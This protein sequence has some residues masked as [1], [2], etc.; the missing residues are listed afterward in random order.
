MGFHTLSIGTSA[1]LTARYGLDVTGQN[2]GNI[3]TPG[4][5][6]QRLN[7]YGSVNSSSALA[8]GVTGN[9]VWVQ[10]IRRV[11]NE[12][13]EKQ[14]RQATSTDEYYGGLSDGYTRLQGYINELRY[15]E[16]DGNA[17]SDTMNNFW[18]AFKD[19]SGGVENLSLRKTPVEMA[20][21]MTGRFNTLGQQLD[22]YRRDLDEEIG[23]SVSQIN[24]ILD[25]IA[26]LNKSIVSSELGGATGKSANDLRD[27]RGE[28]VKELYEYI[29]AD[30]V[31][32]A[33]GSFIVSVHGRN[34]VYFDQVKE[35]VNVKTMSPDGIQVNTPSF[36]EDRYPLNPGDGKL[37]AQMELRDTIIP[38]Y[39]T[40]VDQ[41]AGNFIWEFN[42]VYSQTRGLEP[43]TNMTAKNGPTNP[44]ATLNNLKYLEQ[45]IVPGTFEI[46]DGDFDIV[47]VNK[48]TGESYT[49]TVEIDLDGRPGPDGEPDTILYDPNNPDA[50]N[51]LINRLQAKFDDAVPG[52]F[53]VSIDRNNQ[54]TITAKSSDY[55]FAFANDT[56]GVLAALGMNTFFT[57]HNATTM[58][59]DDT[60]VKNPSLM[61]AAYSGNSGDNNGALDILAVQNKKLTTL[62]GMTMDEHYQSMVGRLGTEANKTTNARYLA[63]DIKNR[64]FNQRESLSGVS[65]DEEVAKLITYQRSFQSAAKFISTVDSL[66]ETLINM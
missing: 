44:E 65:E 29:D 36:A 55:G 13:V 41:L 35:L 10:S 43:Y 4:Y 45:N 20:Q 28:L 62:S 8:N 15:G 3:D 59:V 21:A 39:T 60:Y 61:G 17:L 52:A 26:D 7:Q 24:R 30:V 51:S 46:K 48:N 53:T 5:S 23:A 57:G 12:Y 14:L 27:Q 33:N 1:I 63:A 31:E 47:I 6:R 11:G 32:E 22:T 66:Y 54:V 40:E 37:A 2:L 16:I 50:S 49:R 9:G 58:G 42:R 18:N 56:S 19:F 64:M 34:L 25:G 38:S